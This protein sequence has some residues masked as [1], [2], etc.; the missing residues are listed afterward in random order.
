MPRISTVLSLCYTPQASDSSLLS[1]KFS[2]FLIN[3]SYEH[4]WARDGAFSNSDLLLAGRGATLP[5]PVITSGGFLLLEYRGGPANGS[6]PAGGFLA[7]V[8]AVREWP[9]GMVVV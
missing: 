4:V 8:V 1:L 9:V 5:P 2:Y 7:S 3:T 6:N